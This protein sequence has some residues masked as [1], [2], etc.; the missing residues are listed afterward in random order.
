MERTIETIDMSETYLSIGDVVKDVIAR[1]EEI[2][3]EQNGQP[4]AVVMPAEQY[5][6]WQQGRQAFFDRMQAISQHVNMAEE[7]AEELISEAIISVRRGET[8]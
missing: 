2:I 7:E 8:E 5:R 1:G 3:V 4:V 6:Q